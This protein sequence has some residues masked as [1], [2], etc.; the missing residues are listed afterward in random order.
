LAGSPEQANAAAF[1]ARRAAALAPVTVPVV[2]GAALV[3]ARCRQTQEALALVR[4]IFAYDPSA[5]ARLLAE[6]EPFAEARDLDGAIPDDPAAWLAWSR[7]LRRS[8]RDAESEGRLREALDR[9]PDHLP[10]VAAFAERAV[11]RADWNALGRV[12]PSN[13][14]PAGGAI[15]STILAYRAR[16]R[17]QT[18]DVEGARADAEEAVRQAGTISA[19]LTLAGDAMAAASAPVRARELWTR[20]LHG[21]PRGDSQRSTRVALWTRLAR[22]EERHGRPA[23][24]MRAWRAVTEIEPG[25]AEARRRLDD[26]S[27]FRR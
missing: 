11:A 20:A 6:L 25:N 21:L 24:A 2:G 18:G 7:Q 8:G 15:D 14:L 5:A 12:L 22:L 23:D 3:L 16:W 10:T 26:L 17:A 27:G 19:I 9:W 13:P 4:S 1:H